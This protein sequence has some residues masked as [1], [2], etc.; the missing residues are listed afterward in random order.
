MKF[1][2][3]SMASPLKGLAGWCLS[4]TTAVETVTF[5]GRYVNIEYT[6]LQP[7]NE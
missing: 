7:E 6:S 3:L 5:S 2:M 4:Q 1:C